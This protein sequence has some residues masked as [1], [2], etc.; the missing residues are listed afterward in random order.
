MDD[1]EFEA[2]EW[3]RA[4][5]DLGNQTHAFHIVV[6]WKRTFFRPEENQRSLST[7]S[8]KLH[9]EQIFQS[10]LRISSPTV[11]KKEMTLSVVSSNSDT[12]ALKS[13]LETLGDVC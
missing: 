6:I 3:P 8:Q 13:V 10:L 9:T 5:K 7:W 2:V 12:A 1:R 11:T 4:V